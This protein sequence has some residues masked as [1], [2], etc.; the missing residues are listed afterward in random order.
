MLHVKFQDHRFLPYTGP[1]A[2]LITWP[3]KI[4]IVEWSEK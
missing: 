1:A 3:G 4:A 2:I